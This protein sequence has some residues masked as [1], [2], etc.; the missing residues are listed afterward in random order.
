MRRASLYLLST[1]LL[2]PLTTPAVQA[3]PAAQP[4]SPSANDQR[5]ADLESIRHARAQLESAL[6]Q[7]ESRCRRSFWVHGCLKEVRETFRREVAELDRRERAIETEL[8][9]QRA[10]QALERVRDK[11]QGLE[12]RRS[13]KA[14]PLTDAEIEQRLDRAQ[15]ERA[16]QAQERLLRQQQRQTAA[17]QRNEARERAARERL[18]RAERPLA[19]GADLPAASDRSTGVPLQAPR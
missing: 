2:G 13:P 5:P 15:E 17:D 6:L 1:L 8:R 11:L 4:A 7:Q 16:E 3:W 18:E 9:Q 10:Q 19:S 12:D 14:L